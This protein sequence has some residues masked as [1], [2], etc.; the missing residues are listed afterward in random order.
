MLE[1]LHNENEAMYPSPLISLGLEADS[2]FIIVVQGLRMRALCPSVQYSNF[3]SFI[4]FE[5]WCFWVR[6][7]GSGV[8]DQRYTSQNILACACKTIRF[9]CMSV[10]A[11]YYK[12]NRIQAHWIPIKR[13]KFY[14]HNVWLLLHAAGI[15]IQQPQPT[16]S[17]NQSSCA[18]L[19]L[20]PRSIFVYSAADSNS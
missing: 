17:T 14:P 5:T 9:N 2:C 1:I 16:K 18:T 3:L 4:I 8:C 15:S 6:T 12:S 11:E 19:A 20:L 10:F 7:S 13:R